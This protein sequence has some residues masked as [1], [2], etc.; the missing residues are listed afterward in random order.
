MFFSGEKNRIGDKTEI[1]V[2]LK[3]LFKEL[4]KMCH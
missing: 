2:E 4:I 3:R 1:N